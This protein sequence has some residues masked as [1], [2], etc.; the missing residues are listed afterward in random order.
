M[1]EELY[2]GSEE[3][4]MGSAEGATSIVRNYLGNVDLSV[5]GDYLVVVGVLMRG[6]FLGKCFWVGRE[7]WVLEMYFPRGLR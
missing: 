4:D 1:S 3:V 6:C 5:W 7:F 2:I